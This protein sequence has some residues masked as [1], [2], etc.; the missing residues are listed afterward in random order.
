[1][2]FAKGAFTQPALNIPSQHTE[3]KKRWHDGSVKFAV[4]YGVGS[5]EIAVKEGVNTQ[6]AISQDLTDISISIDGVDIKL[7]RFE[8]GVI[9]SRYRALHDDLLV[10]LTVRQ[11]ADG[12]RWARFAVENG[13]VNKATQTKEYK[14]VVTIG[15]EVLNQVIL[16]DP[17]T[18]WIADGW[19]GEHAIAYQDIDYL[20]STGLVPNY[21]AS[22][23]VP[24]GSYQSYSVGEIGNHTKGMGAGGYQYQIGLLPGWDASY[25]ASG[26]KEAYQSVIAN[27]KAIGSYPIAWRDYDTL[28]QIDLDKFNQWTVSGYKQGGANQVCSTAGCWE[29]AHFPSTGYLAYLLT[30]DPVHLDTL[31]HTA[32]LCYLI[33]NWGYGGG[34]G[35]ERLSLGQTRGQA[36]CWRSIGMYTA[37]TDDQDFNDMLSFNFARFAQDIDKNEIGVTYIGNISAYGRG[38]IAPWMQNFRVQVLGFL[39]DIEP[40]DGMTDLIA[41]RDH[42]YKF[43]VG[44]LGCFDT[45]GSYTLRAGP[46]N[47][48]SIADIWTWGEINPSECGNE[49][50]RPTA[51]SY[52][53]NMLPAISYAVD[54]KADG[55]ESAWQR[56]SNAINFNQFQAGFKLNPVWGV[57]PR[58]DKTGGGEW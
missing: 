2:G 50:T 21:I 9:E 57:F 4:A 53:A 46:E 48:A 18:R 22:D 7:E 20:K 49:I 34:L 36:W 6:T 37:L 56:L 3:V 19:I 17:H 38:V 28:E 40:V 25:L 14:A 31:A 39:S 41:L 12:T 26:S 47:T 52:W 27:A 55:A 45:A 51:T 29:R 54:H 13:Y 1:M 44:L 42:N 16:H 35:K 11:W 30:G 10:L 5:G 23:A 15:D 8:Q 58:L 32:A 24:P 33:Q 43:T